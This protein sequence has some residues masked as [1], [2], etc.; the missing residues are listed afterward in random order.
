MPV[1]SQPYQPG[2]GVVLN[3][4]GVSLDILI[5]EVN[6]SSSNIDGVSSTPSLRRIGTSS[7]QSAAGALVDPNL[8]TMNLIGWQ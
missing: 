3:A 6:V 8:S 2:S 5:T 7:G 4:D 1:S